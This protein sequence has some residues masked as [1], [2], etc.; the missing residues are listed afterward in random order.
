MMTEGRSDHF[1]FGSVSV[2]FGFLG[3]KPVKNRFGLVFRFC[4]V[5]FRFFP[6]WVQFGFFDFRFMKSKLNQTEPVSFFKILIGLINF[7]T[8]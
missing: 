7:F 6:V 5:F 4:S 3:Q 2:R 1:L 8:I